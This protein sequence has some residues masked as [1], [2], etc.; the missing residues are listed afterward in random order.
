MTCCEPV[1]AFSTGSCG[2]CATPT[3]PWGS[4]W[5]DA[6]DDWT[7]S[8]GRPGGL[9]LWRSPG[10]GPVDEEV[11]AGEV[12]P[13][14]E[15]PGFDGR[16]VT[17]LFVRQLLRE[18]DVDLIRA[19]T[20]VEADGT[21][22]EGL[23][24][25]AYG[26]PN[27]DW[28]AILLSDEHCTTGTCFAGY[29]VLAEV[30]FS[31]DSRREDTS[32][33]G[34]VIEWELQVSADLAGIDISASGRW[35]SGWGP[36]SR[37]DHLFTATISIES[38]YEPPGSDLGIPFEARYTLADRDGDAVAVTPHGGWVHCPD[39]DCDSSDP[40]VC[41][42]MAFYFGAQS[43]FAFGHLWSAM[44][45]HESIAGLDTSQLELVL[46]WG[47]GIAAGMDNSRYC[48]EDGSVDGDFRPGV[49]TGPGEAM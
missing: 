4:A 25:L 6:G 35:E 47:A 27:V 48:S 32:V 15:L 10:D 38:A 49:D 28:T 12:E 8:P 29:T 1:R 46:E 41:E 13:D 23:L 20:I 17:W 11:E 14:V 34:I 43:F 36:T 31:S 18:E 26:D 39:G 19:E 5:G 2:R 16:Q 3:R 33:E 21:A 45:R 40:D 30:H 37:S 9:V 7:E 22:V 42:Y 44:L 24:L